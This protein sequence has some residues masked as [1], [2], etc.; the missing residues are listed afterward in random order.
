[1][2]LI[3][4]SRSLLVIDAIQLG[5]YTLN[6][7]TTC[8]PVSSSVKKTKGAK[9][10]GRGQEDWVTNPFA[11]GVIAIIVS[12]GNWTEWSTIQGVFGRVILNRPS[13]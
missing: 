8:I 6:R 5:D 12:N 2:V 9:R 1:M 4:E 7:Q 10:L 13:P 3:S 11:I